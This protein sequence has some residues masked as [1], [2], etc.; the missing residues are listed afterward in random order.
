MPSPEQ[1]ISGAAF[2]YADTIQLGVAVSPGR[3]TIL[4]A[5]RENKWDVREP[6]GATGGT[7]TFHGQK[8]AKVSIR[9]DLWLPEQIPLWDLFAKAALEVSRTKLALKVTHPTL[10]ASPLNIKEVSIESVGALLQDEDGMWSAEIQLLEY[11]PPMP[12]V[13][14]PR[15]AIPNGAKAPP[16]A[17]DEAEAQIAAL[18]TQVQAAAAQ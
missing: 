3:C 8:I 5:S 16:T 11:K 18:I 17:A 15:A 7:T 9:I 2:P 4:S 12:I 1:V 14:K 13:A 10:N 6:Y